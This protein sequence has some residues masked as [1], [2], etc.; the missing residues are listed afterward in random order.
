MKKLLTLPIIIN[1]LLLTCSCT[2]QPYRDISE[3]CAEVN[4]RYGSPLLDFPSYY[5]EGDD[6]YCFFVSMGGADVIVALTQDESACVTSARL[7]LVNGGASLSSQAQSAVYECFAIICGVLDSRPTESITELF[8]R[9]SFSESTV[10]FTE[11]AVEIEDGKLS[12]FIWT[13]ENVISL[14]CIS[15]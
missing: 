10:S 3:F 11:G 12:V 15:A 14:Y 9:N 2:S 8:S 13:N 6:E 4:S 5:T 7:S 1:I